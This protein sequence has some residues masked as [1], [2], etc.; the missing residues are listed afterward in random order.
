[1]NIQEML[2]KRASIIAQ[3]RSKYD[4][5]Q[6]QG[7]T[8]E[9]ESEF[10]KAMDEAESID[11]EVR[12]FKRLNSIADAK[13]A[14]AIQSERKSSV[15][16]NGTTLYRSAFRKI[17]FKQQ[18]Q[19]TPEE[20]RAIQEVRALQTNIPTGNN[21]VD[22]E[23]EKRIV[24]GL[25][26]DNIFT[27]ANGFTV[28]TTRTLTQYPLLNTPVQVAWQDEG[29]SFSETTPSFA[30][31]QFGAWRVGG[32]T[33]LSIEM[34]ED[35]YTEPPVEVWLA[36]EFA[37][38]IG[39]SCESKYA[40]GTGVKS[41]KGLFTA[42][43]NT[44]AATAG[45]PTGDDYISLMAKLPIQYRKSASF[46]LTDS[47]WAPLMKLKG[48]DGH[49]I[50]IPSLRDGTPGTLLGRPC[51]FVANDTTANQ[52][53]IVDP[54][55]FVIANRKGIYTRF[56][57]EAKIVDGLYGVVAWMRTDSNLLLAEASAKL[58]FA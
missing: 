17:L 30:N 36:D 16:P 2:E 45:T 42:T 41:P 54:R 15:E 1:M 55:Y 13:E 22:I 58:T 39:K 46:V 38:A 31:M 26:R 37:R 11:R 29:Q 14:I 3:A 10:M 23:F 24:Q 47:L 7:L 32:L 57:N 53:C 4:S 34:Q 44:V 48:T 27:A 12:T 9:D 20:Q 40:F 6:G 8:A 43:T 21:L 35:A 50:Y 28:R 52:A 51:H 5:K 25:D 33:W 56:L 18:D 49:Y 19:I